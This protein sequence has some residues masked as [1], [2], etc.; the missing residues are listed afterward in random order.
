[1]VNEDY[2]SRLVQVLKR[3]DVHIEDRTQGLE[4]R[5]QLNNDL[6]TQG[7]A[8]ALVAWTSTKKYILEEF[9]EVK[10]KYE[11]ENKK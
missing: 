4:L 11:F 2:V 8:D 3:I 10:R 9:P 6:W 7:A 5:K 1:M